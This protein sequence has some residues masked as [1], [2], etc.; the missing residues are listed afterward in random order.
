MKTR[1][2]RL[3]ARLLSHKGYTIDQTILIVAII[4]ILITLVI[5]TVGWT[6]INRTSG[7]K[8]AAQL[9]QVEDANASFYSSVKMWPHTGLGASTNA[10]PSNNM[11][12]ITNWSAVS[13]TL[14][15]NGVDTSQIRNQLP[16]YKVTGS[17]VYHGLGNGLGIVTQQGIKVGSD[18]YMVVMLTQVPVADANEADKA[19]D[20]SIDNTTGRVQ[21]SNSTACFG[22]GGYSSTATYT[23]PSAAITTSTVTLCYLANT[24]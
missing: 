11:L 17:N 7:T 10:T 13:G 21:Y 2:N 20:G 15:T 23:P 14:G 18:N 5:I 3:F 9:K 24:I 12:A 16:G 22:T 8:A 19:I 6:L 4:A 1:T